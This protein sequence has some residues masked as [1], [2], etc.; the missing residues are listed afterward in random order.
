MLHVAALILALGPGPLLADRADPQ[1]VLLD[2]G[3]LCDVKIDGH[4][5][6][7][8]TESGRINVIPQTRE[9][10]VTTARVPARLGLSFG[11]RAALS[12][13]ADPVDARIVVTHPPLGE[14]GVTVQSWTARLE[15]GEPA[16]N[17]FTFE[18]AYETVT[19]RW[20]FE[21]TGPD[22]T[23]LRQVF[24]VVGGLAVPA[25]QEACFDAQVVSRAGTPRPAGTR[26]PRRRQMSRKTVS[27][28]PCRRMSKR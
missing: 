22:G 17:L 27:C 13:D 16:L 23:M 3:V 20:R 28:G 18:Y 25:V 7:P 6:A 10:D 2:H 5:D 8:G 1:I 21:I 15:P 12:P 14:T 19:G 26:R 9:I 11:I 24:E 4:R